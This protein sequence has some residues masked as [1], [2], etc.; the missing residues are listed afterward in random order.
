M[1]IQTRSLFYITVVRDGRTW[2]FKYD[3]NYGTDPLHFSEKFDDAMI[4]KES[5]INGRI[6]RIIKNGM[7]I[8]YE[9]ESVD[10]SQI[11]IHEIKI[12]H[13]AEE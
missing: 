8:G 5:Y 9:K 6:K 4:S 10:K 2:F 12:N 3:P 7:W 13:G 11:K 1:A